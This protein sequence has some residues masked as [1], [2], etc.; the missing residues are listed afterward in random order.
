MTL[1]FYENSIMDL[2]LKPSPQQSKAGK[3]GAEKKYGGGYGD[4][5]RR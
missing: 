3:G 1:P 5:T 2:V 4:R